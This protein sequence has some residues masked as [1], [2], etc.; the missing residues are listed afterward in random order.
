MATFDELMES[1]LAEEYLKRNRST[2]PSDE[3]SFVE[4]EMK[5]NAELEAQRAATAEAEALSR[6]KKASEPSR[7]GSKLMSEQQ[8]EELKARISGKEVSEKAEQSRQEVA[9]RKSLE[10]TP[11]EYAEL[12][13]GKGATNLEAIKEASLAEQEA[14]RAAA[15]E[16]VDKKILSEEMS[17]ESP[18]LKSKLL[19]EAKAEEIKK[20][21]SAREEARKLAE[22]RGQFEVEPTPSRS[23]AEQSAQTFERALKEQ[24]TSPS[25][26]SLVP[27]GITKG[28]GVLVGEPYGGNVA[29][30]EPTVESAGATKQAFE[31]VP[32]ER[33]LVPTKG[34][35]SRIPTKLSSLDVGT[36]GGFALAGHDIYKI[37]KRWQE[38]GGGTEGYKKLSKENL[39]KVKDGLKEYLPESVNKYAYFPQE[40]ELLA[41]TKKNIEHKKLIQDTITDFEVSKG[42]DPYTQVN[43]ETGAYGRYQVIPRYHE[44]AIKEKLGATWDEFKK[45]PELQDKYYND[46]LYPQYVAG[47]KDILNHP[48]AE[49]LGINE[50]QAI[51]LQQLGKQNVMNWLEGKEF[52]GANASVPGQINYVLNKTNKFLAGKGRGSGAI[53]E[54]VLASTR[55]EPSEEKPVAEEKPKDPISALVDKYG[56]QQLKEKLSEMQGLRQAQESRDLTILMNQL[57]K[58]AE[59]IANNIGGLVNRGIITKPVA[60]EIYNQNIKQAENIVTDFKENLAV[61]KEAKKSDPSSEDSKVARELLKSLGIDVS[62][63]ASAAFIEKNFPSLASFAKS[64]TLAEERKEQKQKESEVKKVEGARRDLA[65]KVTLATTRGGATFERLKSNIVQADSIFNTVGTPIVE[66]E[67]EIDKLDGKKLNEAAKPQIA[68]IAMELN[69][70]LS[71]SSSGNRKT[72]E[73]L[74]PNTLSMSASDLE[75]YFTNKLTPAKQASFLKMALKTGIRQKALAKRAI[76]NQKRQVFAGTKHLRDTLGD[77]YDDTISLVAEIDKKQIPEFISGKNEKIQKFADKH[78][79]GDYEKAKIVFEKKKQELIEKKKQELIEKKKQESGYGR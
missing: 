2:V 73:T 19:D 65:R 53:G 18:A 52:A 9:R 27:T 47:S 38:L 64:R 59:I 72:F 29:V 55:E 58:S 60:T 49:E 30:L 12:V 4:Q 54:E 63:K 31:S 50:E 1:G 32:T 51:A 62:E 79:N 71:G 3:L 8:A 21:I 77:E 26:K 35:D 44:K 24:A 57:G 23:T 37:L 33:A 67:E 42:K 22:R 28:P 20:T 17:K 11:E 45:S 15:A 40:D 76:L 39:A 36:L 13:K 43:P 75:N 69:K 34:V 48:R 6:A 68:E 46:V 61:Q 74:F 7:L 10:V 41:N 5:R 16:A 66:S 70:L 78:F 56:D 25:S 14:Q